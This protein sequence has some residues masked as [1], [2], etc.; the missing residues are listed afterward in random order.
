MAFPSA[1]VTLISIPSPATGRAES[2][3]RTLLVSVVVRDAAST[4]EPNTFAGIVNSTPE[5]LSSKVPPEAGVMDVDFVGSS[6]TVVVRV[7]FFPDTE[8]PV[9]SIGFDANAA[10][11]YP[12]A[13]ANTLQT[14]EVTASE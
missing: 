3:S 7:I 10:S 1:S 13:T 2:V 6:A 14:P 4:S 9:T 8:P 5:V 12:C 11:A